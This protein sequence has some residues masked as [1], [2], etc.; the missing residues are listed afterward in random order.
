MSEPYP[1]FPVKRAVREKREYLT[2]STLSM[3][4]VTDEPYDLLAGVSGLRDHEK[5]APGQDACYNN[6]REGESNVENA[7]LHLWL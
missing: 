6:S 4:N 1:S 3:D 7:C 5:D 2:P